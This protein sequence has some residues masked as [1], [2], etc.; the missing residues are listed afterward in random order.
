M[1]YNSFESGPNEA[2]FKKLS[3]TVATSIQKI[4]QN[5]KKLLDLIR[6]SI[7][8]INLLF[9]FSIVYESNG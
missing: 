9:S 3:Q 1:S 7:S 6:K 5:G 4:W 2:E 8:Y